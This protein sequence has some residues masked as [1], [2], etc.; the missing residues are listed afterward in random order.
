VDKKLKNGHQR[1]LRRQ[2]VLLFT[3][4]FLFFYSPSFAENAACKYLTNPSLDRM[5]REDPEMDRNNEEQLKKLYNAAR[6][7]NLHAMG[8]L[9]ICYSY[10]EDCAGLRPDYFAAYSW[11]SLVKKQRPLT[12]EETYAFKTASQDLSESKRGVAEQCIQDWKPAPPRTQNPEEFRFDDYD[13][14]DFTP[15]FQKLFP[16]GTPKSFVDHVLVEVGGAQ[17]SKVE[18]IQKAVPNTVSKLIPKYEAIPLK[19]TYRYDYTD[20]NVRPF[21]CHWKI[22]IYFDDHSDV[23][24]LEF[25]ASIPDRLQVKQP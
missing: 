16:A 11:L 15:E 22:T 18:S 13:G 5:E 10:I 1:I 14:E 12:Q 8:G 4:F 21:G 25:D 6:R 7:G 3:T 23:E 19:N 17:S 20:R 9:G 2:L 24:K